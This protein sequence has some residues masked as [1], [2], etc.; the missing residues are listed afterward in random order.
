[1]LCEHALTLA[2]SYQCV[3]LVTVWTFEWSPQ[4]LQWSNRFDSAIMRQKLQLS[5]QA[6]LDDQLARGYMW[7]SWEAF[8][9]YFKGL[10]VCKVP[11]RGVG[12]RDTGEHAGHWNLVVTM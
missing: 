12:S 6:D 3:F 9:R 8:L 10:S 2:L 7:I 11:I 5:S 4:S 1:M